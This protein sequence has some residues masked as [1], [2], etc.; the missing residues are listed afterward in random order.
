MKKPHPS[1]V[2]TKAII[3]YGDLLDED[4]DVIICTANPTLSLSGGIGGAILERGGLSI[5]RELRDLLEKRT[6]HWVEPGT[7]VR[8]GAGFLGVKHLLH[9]VGVDA[10]YH[11]SVDL[12]TRGISLA[13][14]MAASLAAKTV[15]C[16]AIATGHGPLTI[17]QFAQALGRV[18]GVDYAPVQEVRFVLKRV[19]DAKRVSS[20]LGVSAE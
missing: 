1:R 5:Q 16:P 18:V 9:V 7:V 11:S 20:L 17:D 14:T 13:L 12:V 4:V 6:H 15:A 3:K 19:K 2:T 8:T 10:F